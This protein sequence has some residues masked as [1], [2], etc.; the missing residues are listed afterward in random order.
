MTEID[1]NQPE[2]TCAMCNVVSDEPSRIIPTV[3]GNTLCPKCAA[4]AASTLVM[5]GYNE[6]ALALLAGIRARSTW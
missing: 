6:Q 2:C 5:Y 4:S 1:N 3:G